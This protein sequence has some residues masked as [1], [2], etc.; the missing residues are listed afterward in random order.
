MGILKQKQLLMQLKRTLTYEDS[1]DE[2]ALWTFRTE[3]NN[4]NISIIQDKIKGYD[5]ELLNIFETKPNGNFA[6][7]DEENKQGLIRDQ[8]DGDRKALDLYFERVPQK[9]LY[10]CYQWLYPME[11]Y[12]L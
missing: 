4:L 3:D 1:F 12:V 9:T 2:Y 6:L 10:I 8:K 7:I 11:G 5:C